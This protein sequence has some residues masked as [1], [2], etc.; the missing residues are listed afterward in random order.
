MGIENNA[1]WEY[2]QNNDFALN[3]KS[4]PAKIK[5]RRNKEKWRK[6][7][8][9]MRNVNDYE[10]I[11]AHKIISCSTSEDNRCI[12]LFWFQLRHKIP[13]FDVKYKMDQISDDL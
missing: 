1:E 13:K 11:N 7:K 12:D 8:M 10:I 6:P 4:R 3:W 5:N 2:V 9:E